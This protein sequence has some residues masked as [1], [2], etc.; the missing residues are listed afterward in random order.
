MLF[1]H[2]EDAFTPA[3]PEALLKATDQVGSMWRQP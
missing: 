1:Q 3:A 2:K